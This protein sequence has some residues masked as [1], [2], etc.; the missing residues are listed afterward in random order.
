M[1]LFS[2]ELHHNGSAAEDPG[3]PFSSS[4]HQSTEFGSH[5]L[6]LL[7]FYIRLLTLTQ[8]H[9]NKSTAF[10]F[11]LFFPKSQS[12]IVPGESWR[13]STCSR[14]SNLSAL[15]CWNELSGWTM[16]ER[17]KQPFAWIW[18]NAHTTHTQ[19]CMQKDISCM[20]HII[21]I[22]HDASNN[23]YCNVYNVSQ[24]L[25]VSEVFWCL[26]KQ[27][28]GQYVISRIFNTPKID[29]DIK[30]SNCQCIAKCCS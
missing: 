18:R 9:C 21:L 30:L 7:Q 26:E 12:S 10:F 23:S 6:A 20:T 15:C 24:N 17:G 29:H 16:H 28:K 11:L 27:S 19:P 25:F 14:L 4:F 5:L 1:E 8:L 13:N 3:T 22:C 2:A